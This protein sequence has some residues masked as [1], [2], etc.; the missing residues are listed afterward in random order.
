[1]GV[2]CRVNKNYNNGC[3]ARVIFIFFAS[4]QI[5]LSFAKC[6]FFFHLSLLSYNKKSSIKHV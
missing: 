2:G 6:A 1:M 4:I 5:D 3:G